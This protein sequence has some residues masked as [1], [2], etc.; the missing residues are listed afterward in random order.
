MLGRRR[1]HRPTPPTVLVRAPRAPRPAGADRRWSTPSPS[2]RHVARR[3][4]GRA[5]RRSSAVG[6]GAARPGRPRRRAPRARPHLP[7]SSA[8]PLRRRL[9]R[10]ARPAGRGRQ[11]RQLRRLGRGRRRR[12]AAGATRR[13]SL[14][15]LGTGI[16]GGLVDRRRACCAGP[17]ASPASPATWWSTR[18]GRRARAAAAAAGSATPP[19]AGSAAWPATRPTPAGRRAL[20]ALAGGDP[21]AVRGEHVAARPRERRPRCAGRA[22]RASPGGSASAWPTWS[23]CST[24][25]WCVVGGGLADAADLLPRPGPRRSARRGHSVG[26]PA[27]RPPRGGHA[28]LRRRR[29]RRRAAWRSRRRA[30]V[31]H[32]VTEGVRG[33]GAPADTLAAMEFRR[34]NVAA[35]RTSSRSSTGLKIEARRAGDDVIDLGFGNPDLPVARH[36][37]REAVP[38][39]RTTPA[40]TATRPAG[41]SRSCARPSPTSTSA[42][43]ASS[44]TPTPRSSPPSAP[45]RASPT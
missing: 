36:R 15:T 14:V 20:V 12:P 29:H 21:E 9:G 10:R 6:V 17:T 30:A 32:E 37:G 7:A 31:R 38:R 5:R 39:R 8:L 3:G 27:A 18:T 41:A 23:T 35:A 24:P 26:R 45:R 42:G 34:I 40:T 2:S 16:G 33:A 22:R 43:S 28:R 25:R 13:R 1:R 4:R 19:A 11:R 44:S